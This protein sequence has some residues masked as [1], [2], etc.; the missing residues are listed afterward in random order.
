MVKKSSSR[1]LG[2]GLSALIGESEADAMDAEGI[3]AATVAQVSIVD[4]KPNPDQ[5]RRRFDSAELDELAASLRLRG[6]VQ[7]LIVRPD[8]SGEGWQI[9]AGERRWRAAQKA[10]L[11][12]VPVVI[13]EDLSESDVLEIA[14]VENV[15]RSDLNPVEEARAYSRLI[16]DFGHTQERLA[17]ALGKSRSHLANTLRL[18]SLPD[19]AL[20][21]LEAGR[22]SAGHARALI[23]SPDPARLAAEVAARGLSVR[24]TEALARRIK[25]DPSPQRRRAE[26]D[27]DTM[28]LE[29]DL[30]AALG[31]SVRIEHKSGS[32][33]A[34][35]ELRII[36]KDLDE[37]D[38]ICRLLSR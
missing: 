30:T 5:P 3:G 10:Q 29:A 4:L 36:Y 9:I 34:A 21:L 32:E 24:Q 37:L 15:Q 8:P 12:E 27:P 6:V 2:R 20:D 7:P 19:A 22:I 38:G 11:H 18:L 35:G 26:K 17:A 31:L 13:R 33:G 23:G 28:A 25:I 1:G 14:L 16:S